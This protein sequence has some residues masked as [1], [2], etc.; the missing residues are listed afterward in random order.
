MKYISEEQNKVTRT[1]LHPGPLGP[2]S[3]TLAIRPPSLKTGLYSPILLGNH[4]ET[5]IN[6]R[7]QQ[8]LFLKK[9]KKDKV[10]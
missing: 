1:G 8:Q 4:N 9:K 6:M 3:N 10:Q 2:E 7:Q 5:K